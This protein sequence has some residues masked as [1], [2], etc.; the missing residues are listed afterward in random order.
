MYIYIYVYI[1]VAWLDKKNEHPLVERF[2]Y[3][4][5]VV[6]QVCIFF[7]KTAFW[8]KRIFICV[9]FISIFPTPLTNF[10][11]W[12]FHSLTRF[13][14]CVQ[15]P[16]FKEPFRSYVKATVLHFGVLLAV[17]ECIILRRGI[18]CRLKYKLVSVKMTNIN[19][20]EFPAS[21]ENSKNK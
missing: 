2:M 8:L 3:L 7:P 5:T 11:L 1:Y 10:V 9:A 13:P 19:P 12:D 6:L 20:E 16:I 14:N 17:S 15:L 18:V 4:F 21:E